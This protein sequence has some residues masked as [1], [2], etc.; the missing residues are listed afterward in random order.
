MPWKEVTIMSQRRAFVELAGKA[1]ANMR[2][3]CRRFGI[4]PPTGYKWLT[5]YREGGVPVLQDQSRRP[6]RSPA[7]TADT[8]EAAVLAE[9]AVHPTWGGRKLQRR[10]VN[11]GRHSVPAPSTITAI[12][13]RHGQLDA[14]ANATHRPWQRFEAPFPN[15][16][17]QMD[18]KGHFA[19]GNHRRCHPLT[20]LDDCSRFNVG[21]VACGDEGGETVRDCLTPI[22]RCYG[23]PDR[24]LMDNGGPWGEGRE[25]TKLAVWLLRL[26][27]AVSHGRPYHPQTQGKDERFHRTLQAELLGNRLFADHAH[28]QAA[29]DPW[30]DS[31]NFERPHEALGLATPA[32][33]YTM[34]RRPFPE[35]LPAIE[36]GPGDQVR[37]VQGNGEL[38]FL[39][40][41]LTVGRAFI[42][43]PVALR[44]TVVDGRWEVFYCRQHLGGID[45]TVVPKNTKRRVNH[46]SE[47][48]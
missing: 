14:A 3:L 29:F 18:F 16:L 21:L 48:V 26:D 10:L 42:G 33:R 40:R 22:F 15:A 12:L 1:G 28:C 17:W 24:M 7:Q 5:R 2:E 47:H 31:Y 20:V 37:K 46:V 34:S 39:G 8:M 23:L 27:I 41:V 25:Y 32:S 13:R 38:Y 35:R 6:Q 30:R 11:L 19:L 36:Y 9:R 43:E 44:P 45:L 4:S